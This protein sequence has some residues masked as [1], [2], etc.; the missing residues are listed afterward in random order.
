MRSTFPGLAAALVMAAFW[1]PR[2]IGIHALVGARV[3]VKPGEVMGNATVVIRDGRIANVLGAGEK[4]PAEARVWDMN[5]KTIYAGFIDPYLS[6]GGQ[7][8]KPVSNRWHASV[9]ARSG[10]AFR[11]VD[12][13][14]SDMGTKGPGYEVAEVH[15]QA[16]VAKEFAPDNKAFANLRKLGFTAGNFIP[17]EGILRG[18]SALALLGE[19]D[20]NRLILKPRTA[21]HLALSP[22]QNYALLPLSINS[23]CLLAHRLPWPEVSECRFIG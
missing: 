12:T 20:P 13:T 3:V 1:N 19:G 8:A 4:V 15:P 18:Q 17:T 6:I 2:P 22:A 11:G 21:Q 10:I 9:D 7:K 16:E 14:K 23:I 5:G